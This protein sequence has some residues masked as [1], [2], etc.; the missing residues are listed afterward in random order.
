MARSISVAETAKI[1]SFPCAALAL[2]QVNSS[3]DMHR[4]VD[5]VHRLAAAVPSLPRRALRRSSLL[6]RLAVLMA[7]A[8]RHI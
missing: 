1:M 8:H 4:M 5:E 6:E 3:R 2:P 7:P